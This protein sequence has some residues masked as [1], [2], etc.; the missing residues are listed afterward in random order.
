MGAPS[1]P[2]VQDTSDKD[3]TPSTRL[4]R[5]LP[6]EN[7]SEVLRARQTNRPSDPM[8]ARWPEDYTR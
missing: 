7:R 8:P 2:V 5:H 6:A 1:G 4:A 3:G